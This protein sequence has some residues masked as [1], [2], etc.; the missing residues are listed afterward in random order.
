MLILLAILM[1]TLNPTH[2][3]THSLTHYVRND[4]SI[5]REG[6]TAP[7]PLNKYGLQFMI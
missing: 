4:W 3:L 2:S 6:L 7:P 5:C 1:V